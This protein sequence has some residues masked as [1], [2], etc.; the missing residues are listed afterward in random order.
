MHPC[1]DSVHAEWEE[2]DWSI[3]V[4]TFS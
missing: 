4:G 2:S 3:I 1:T